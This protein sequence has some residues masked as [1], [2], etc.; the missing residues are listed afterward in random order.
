MS[1]ATEQLEER[2]AA[3]HEAQQRVT[4][5]EAAA[6][7]GRRRLERARG[8]L[9]GYFEQLG[10]GEIEADPEEERRLRAAVTEAQQHVSTR[11]VLVDGATVD[12]TPVDDEAEA[13]LE[14]AR[15]ALEDRRNE[16]RSFAAERL[17]DLLAERVPISLE[18]AERLRT[19]LAHLLAADRSWSVEVG[20]YRGLASLAGRDELAA[21]LPRRSDEQRQALA[22]WDDAL[23]DDPTAGRDELAAELPRRS[24]EQRQAL[25]QW[26]DALRDD[27]TAFVPVPRSLLPGPDEA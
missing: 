21:E 24:D 15:R 25:A 14:G 19:A 11:P 6:L 12:F 16:L 10:A 5:A 18:V 9:L 23:R 3:A 26:D 22:Q 20:H 17:G 8:P 1:P 7:Q 27:P 13:R 2:R 4:E